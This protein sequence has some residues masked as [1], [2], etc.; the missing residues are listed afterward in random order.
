MWTMVLFGR[1]PR[2]MKRVITLVAAIVFTLLA[3]DLKILACSWSIDYFYQ[4]TILKGTVVGSDFPVL[5]LFRW[6]RQSVPLSK[7]RLTLYDFC[8]PCDV[9]SRTPVKTVVTGS[10][11]KFDFGTL[12]PAHYFLRI[13]DEKR[14]LSAWFQ[15]EVKDAHGPKQSEVIDISPVHPDCSGG[16]EFILR[17]D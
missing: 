15:I 9:S 12:K 17:D 2:R 5:H 14:A 13:I 7:A 11:G 8:W 3:A 16:H 1:G 10:D 6:Y 4:L